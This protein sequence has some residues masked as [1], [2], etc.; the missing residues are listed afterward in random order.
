M[1]Q[2]PALPEAMTRIQ[3]NPAV[4]IGKPVVTGIR[5][6]VQTILSYM[7]AGDD[8][9]AVLQAHPQL[10]REDVLACLAYARRLSV[11]HPTVAL[12]S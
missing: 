2:I 10:G 5:T 8:V 4:C 9:D 1:P 6:P 12:T 11:L 3:I 7:S